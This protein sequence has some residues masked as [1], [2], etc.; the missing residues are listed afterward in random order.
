MPG[1]LIKPIMIRAFVKL[2]N[3]RKEHKSE[4]VMSHV[5]KDVAAGDH[6]HLVDIL[7]KTLFFVFNARAIADQIVEVVIN[8]TCI[9]NAE[10]AP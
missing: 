1:N 9:V 4:E 6:L 7:K 5:W 10:L 3:I 2:K 8:L